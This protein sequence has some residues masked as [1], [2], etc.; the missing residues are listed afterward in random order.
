VAGYRDR[1]TELERTAAELA[2]QLERLRGPKP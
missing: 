1:G 2:A